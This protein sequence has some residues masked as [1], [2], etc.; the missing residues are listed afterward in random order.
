MGQGKTLPVITTFNLNQQNTVSNL[1]QHSNFGLR[2][3]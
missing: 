1:S 2:S 3:H